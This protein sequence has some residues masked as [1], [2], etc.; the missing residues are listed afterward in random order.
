MSLHEELR[1]LVEDAVR[2]VVREELS[3]ARE[4]A[5]PDD[6]FLSVSEAA[7]LAAVA[8][9]TIRAWMGSGKLTRYRAGDRVL[10]V[11]RSELLQFLARAGQGGSHAENLMSPEA[12]A[13]RDHAK[14]R[15]VRG[16]RKRQTRAATNDPGGAN[17]S[18]SADEDE[19]ASR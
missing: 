17:M 4:P 19:D 11:R 14:E 9:G 15:R 12:L 16:G 5:A 1:T 18:P 8:K 13:D 3:R 10:R 2:K 7:R 6:D